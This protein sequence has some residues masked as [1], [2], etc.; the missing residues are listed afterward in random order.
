VEEKIEPAIEAEENTSPVV[1]DENT[2][3]LNKV[4]ALGNNR[5]F[6]ELHEQLEGLVSMMRDNPKMRIQ[7]KVGQY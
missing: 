4:Y 7:V 2:F 1:T 6:T 3:S 5:P